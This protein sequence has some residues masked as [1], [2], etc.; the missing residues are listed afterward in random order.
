MTTPHHRSSRRPGALPRPR[1]SAPVPDP[2]LASADDLSL[3]LVSGRLTSARAAAALPQ[4]IA[5]AGR[6]RRRLSRLRPAR[7]ERSVRPEVIGIANRAFVSFPAAITKLTQTI[8]FT[9]PKD[10]ARIAALAFSVHVHGLTRLQDFS[11][12]G[13]LDIRRESLSILV[14]LGELASAAKNDHDNVNR[15]ARTH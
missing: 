2:V 4:I 6:A 9:P 3:S 10:R 11:A 8:R 12:S 7:A 15:V 1:L 5:L 14:R 13:G